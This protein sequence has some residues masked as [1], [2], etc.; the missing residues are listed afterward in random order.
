MPKYKK[1]ISNSWEELPLML[2]QKEISDYM[3]LNIQEVRRWF[4]CK[5]FPEVDSGK[6]E[7]NLFRDWYYKNH[8]NIN[9]KAISRLQ[10]T[11]IIEKTIND[12]I[13]KLMKNKDK[14]VI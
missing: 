11:E 13:N 2:T 6:V 9:Y 5:D 7:K 1:V 14:E 4:G 12:F 8:D 3:G 10:I